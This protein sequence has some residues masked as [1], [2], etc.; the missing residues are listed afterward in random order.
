MVDRKDRF[1][2]DKHLGSKNIN[3]CKFERNPDFEMPIRARF[4]PKHI[5]E[6]AR[7]VQNTTNKISQAVG[8]WWHISRWGWVGPD[9]GKSFGGVGGRK[10]STVILSDALYG[11]G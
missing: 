9:S 5:D 7:I 8:C 4:D 1:Y 6:R 3:I 10:V 11:F 2:V